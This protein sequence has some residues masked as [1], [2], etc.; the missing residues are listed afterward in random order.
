[1][2]ALVI[3]DSFFGNT[4]KVAQTVAEV[5]RSRAEVSLVRVGDIRPEQVQNA[6]LIVI[7][8]PTRGFRP[9]KPVA[10]WLD[11]ITIQGVKSAAFDTR[12]SIRDVHSLLLSVLVKFFGYAAEPIANGLKKKAAPWSCKPKGSSSKSLKARSKRVN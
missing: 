6:D 9:T 8:S 10:A 3:Y 7:G 2:K 1:M 12:L 11:S 5:L 4:E